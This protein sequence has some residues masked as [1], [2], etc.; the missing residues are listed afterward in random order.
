MPD[1]DFCGTVF[2]GLEGA[3]RFNQSIATKV[4]K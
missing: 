4:L 2:L 1:T 3:V